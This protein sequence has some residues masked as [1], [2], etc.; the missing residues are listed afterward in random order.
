M[1][2]VVLVL[3]AVTW[4]VAVV[5]FVLVVRAWLGVVRLAPAGQ[6]F[7]AAMELGFLN[8]P[9]VERRIGSAAAPFVRTHRKGAILFSVCVAAFMVLTLVNIVSGNAA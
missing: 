9:A 5:G 8:Y 3:A 6:R 1:S 7:T 2:T 4:V